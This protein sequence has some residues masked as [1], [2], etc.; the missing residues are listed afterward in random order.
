MNTYVK[1]SMQRRKTILFLSIFI[2]FSALFAEG[3]QENAA[4]FNPS[5]VP[6]LS[7]SQPRFAD[8]DADG[9]MDMVLGSIS[10]KP[11]YMT[12]VGNASSPMFSH[13]E[14]I[15]ENVTELD[16]E[17]GVF[18]DIDNDGD[19]DFITGGYLGLSLYK[20]TGTVNY[21][22]FEKED[23]FFSGLQVGSNP[24]PDLADID[25]DGDD[26]LLVGLSE[27]GSVK[28]YINSGN[29]SVAVFLDANVTVLGDVGLYA[30]P[31]F[32]DPDNDGD[33][34]ILV[35]RD[36]YGF[37]YYQNNGSAETANWQL[38]ASLYAGLG[39]DSYFNSPSMVDINGDGKQDLIYGNY[40]GPLLYYRNSGTTSTPAWTKNTSL[41]GGVLDI[42]GAS[43][44]FFID[45]DGD[46][47]MDMFSGSQ[48]GYTKYFENIG[49]HQGP[50]WKENNSYFS[51]LKHSIYS[52]VAVGDV[53]GNGLPDAI[54]GDLSG[55]L[56][57]HTNTGSGYSSSASALVIAELGGWSAPC[58]IDMD[59]DGD[60][61]I[62]AGN[63]DGNVFYYENQGSATVPMWT[64]IYA[65]FDSID[66]GTN[67]VPALADLDF[68]GDY[69]LVTGD[70]FREIQYFENQDGTW[71]EDTTMFEDIVAKQNTAPAFADLD[72]DGD[73]DLTLGNYDGTFQY[74]ENTHEVVA[75][76]PRNILPDNYQLR[77]YPNPF[78]PSTVISYQLPADSQVQ[79]I[80]HDINGKYITTVMNE[81]QTAGNHNVNFQA[82]AEMSSGVYLYQLVVDGNVADVKKLMLV[83]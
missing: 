32:C 31:V 64:E 82:S 77:N 14:D 78:N 54:V 34:D 55:K 75:I 30:Y 13:S 29:D 59:H 46:G 7:F 8:L 71:V 74:Y 26:D 79:L 42:G 49:T 80:I 50:A 17:M 24:V 67:C 48:M 27:N 65:Y 11:Y 53:N 5:G 36:G 23:D 21:P 18:S 56:Y 70:L 57:Y 12:N 43:S 15:F 4:M 16:A 41:F 3:W 69:D 45:F 20:N 28:I 2:L 81:S 60:L 1:R 39:N 76:A 44:P 9:D 68:D 58:L 40:A 72:G 73:Q 35:G 19:L 25:N 37:I 66:V 33:V 63:E 38:N 22:I 10:A 62:V 52:A 61:D 51:A 47:D 6:S 83:K